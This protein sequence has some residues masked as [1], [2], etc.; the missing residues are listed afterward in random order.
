MTSLHVV[1][2]EPKT[3][4]GGRHSYRCTCESCVLERA[5]R[6]PATCRCDKAAHFADPT[7][8]GDVTCLRCGR[9][10]APPATAL[11]AAA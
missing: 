9:P 1:T 4:H 2:T 5:Q 10:A 11:K 8:G 6:Q 3:S 7:Q